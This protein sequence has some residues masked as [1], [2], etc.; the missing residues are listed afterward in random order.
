MQT[1]LL[2]PPTGR[3]PDARRLRKDLQE[4]T[5]ASAAVRAAALSL[6]IGN[7]QPPAVFAG[8]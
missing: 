6:R 8:S 5:A 1:G 4:A 3:K 7:C 2:A